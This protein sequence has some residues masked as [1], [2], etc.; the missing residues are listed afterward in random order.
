MKKEIFIL[1]LVLLASSAANAQED[2]FKEDCFSKKNNQELK[3]LS[4][5]KSLDPITGPLYARDAKYPAKGMDWSTS[6]F[7]EPWVK[8]SRT[9]PKNRG[10]AIE[11]VEDTCGF[12]AYL[13]QDFYPQT[14]W[15]EGVDG[16]GIGEVI[17]G[18]IS[19]QKSH[20]YIAPGYNQGIEKRN[21]QREGFLAYSRPKEITIYYLV[22]R[23]VDTPQGG[24]TRFNDIVF[25]DK[26]TFKLGEAPGWQKIDIE[27][28]DKIKSYVSKFDSKRREPLIL[29]AIEINSVYEGNNPKYKDKT[30]ISEIGNVLEDSEY[31]KQYIKK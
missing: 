8:I 10:E 31:S 28:Y 19:I 14:F 15:C 1:I 29:V 27:N 9:R 13:A 6:Y 18:V 2:T 23:V 21:S 30:C 5:K 7:A 25:F 26:Q 11:W 24:G 4:Q 22:P 20:F 12:N 16:F 3:L 17:A